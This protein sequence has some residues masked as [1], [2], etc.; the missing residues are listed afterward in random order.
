METNQRWI[1]SLLVG[2]FASFAITKSSNSVILASQ[3]EIS[4][5]LRITEVACA[6]APKTLIYKNCTSAKTEAQCNSTSDCEWTEQPSTVWWLILH[7]PGTFTYCVVSVVIAAKGFPS[8]N[9]TP[10]LV[11]G[12][13]CIAVGQVLMIFVTEAYQFALLE[14]LRLFGSGLFQTFAQCIWVTLLARRKGLMAIVVSTSGYIGLEAGTLL[15]V[16]TKKLSRATFAIAGLACA[17]A[18]CIVPFYSVISKSYLDQVLC[19]VD[20]ENSDEGE[21]REN[22]LGGRGLDHQVDPDQSNQGLDHR[23]DLD[24]SNQDRDDQTDL[25]HRA[26]RLSHRRNQNHRV[27]H[28]DE[29]LDNQVDLD[30]DQCQSAQECACESGDSAVGRNQDI[31]DCVNLIDLT[32]T[33]SSPFWRKPDVILAIFAWHLELFGKKTWNLL[34][35]YRLECELDSSSFAIWSAVSTCV[36]GIPFSLL[37]ANAADNYVRSNNAYW[38]YILLQLCVTLAKVV[39]MAIVLL[40]ENYTLRICLLCINSALIWFFSY[41]FVIGRVA[42]FRKAATFLNAF[43]VLSSQINTCLYIFVNSYVPPKF[44]LL[45]TVASGMGLS[46]VVYLLT[47]VAAFKRRAN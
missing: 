7:I 12:L 16:L 30:L 29:G 41:S 34:S 46:V 43:L 6:P 3:L 31:S 40:I 23:V 44:A 22:D 32:E 39:C 33:S 19:Q 45:L 20:L 38:V 9:W 11:L 21:N 2:I 1:I 18:L 36:L 8:G 28:S 47:F 24:H 27:D 42:N 26:Q 13:C 15:V 17:S 25:D 10:F 37:C 5:Q 35:F 4:K 14:T